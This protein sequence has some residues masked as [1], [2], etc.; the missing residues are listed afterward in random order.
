MSQ[1]CLKIMVD[2]TKHEPLDDGLVHFQLMKFCMN[3]RTQYISS[4]VT[5]PSTEHFGDEGPSGGWFLGLSLCLSGGVG[6]LKS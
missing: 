6:G 3:T 1:N 5:V 2:I 4:N